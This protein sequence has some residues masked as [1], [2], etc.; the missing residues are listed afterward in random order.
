[1]SLT[2]LENRLLRGAQKGDLPAVQAAIAAGADPSGS[3]NS[4]LRPLMV[5]SG[6][7]SVEV[8]NFLLQ[9]GAE[10]EHQTWGDDDHR[11]LGMRATHW[12]VTSGKLDTLLV[13]LK[14]GAVYDAV[15]AQGETCL[16]NACMTDA[17][18]PTCVAMA[19]ALLDAG[20]DPLIEDREGQVALHHAAAQ[21]NPN[22]IDLLLQAKGSSLSKKLLSHVSRWEHTPLQSALESNQVQ[23]V[24]HLLSLGA[25]AT[26]DREGRGNLLRRAVVKNSEPIVRVL[27]EAG[28]ESVGGAARVMPDSLASAAKAGRTRLLKLLLTVGRGD[29][30]TGYWANYYVW[31]GPLLNVAAGYATVDCVGVLLAAGAD[32]RVPDDERQT[33]GDMIG[34]LLAS[35]SKSASFRSDKAAI[36]R[37]LLRGPAYRAR[38]WTWPP[39]AAGADDAVAFPSGHPE[40]VPLGVH[41]FRR[42]GEKLVVRLIGR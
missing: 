15:N 30:T 23:A 25:R 19:K 29:R 12:A 28:L 24:A 34:D 38:S 42:R 36:R 20:A 37:T 39:L 40:K 11:F 1:M 17:S 18:P 31:G 26:V 5:A 7:G 10:M 27:F 8:V 3:S 14:A 6:S 35:G 9:N 21:G 13:L 32:E 2:S 22:M 4:R 33:A 16:M 41:I